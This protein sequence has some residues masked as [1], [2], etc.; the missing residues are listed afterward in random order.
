MDVVLL[1]SAYTCEESVL[2]CS[3]Y[4]S[5]YWFSPPSFIFLL[6]ST[7]VA[8]IY[9]IA[10]QQHY[11]C[12]NK[13]FYFCSLFRFS[14]SQK[15]VQPNETKRLKKQNFAEFFPEQIEHAE[16][17]IKNQQLKQNSRLVST[18]RL[19]YI[20]SRSEMASQLELWLRTRSGSSRC[21]NDP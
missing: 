15:P 6:C 20:H 12:T 21:R 4:R 14:S 10:F 5:L 19:I 11:F 1:L 7:S 17:K 13:V 9:F 18:N 2:S 8:M 3:S 16:L